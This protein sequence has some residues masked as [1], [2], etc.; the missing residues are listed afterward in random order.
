MESYLLRRTVLRSISLMTVFLLVISACI[1]VEFPDEDATSTRSDMPSGPI[2]TTDDL[3]HL[4]RSRN[5]DAIITGLN[6]IKSMSTQGHLLSALDALWRYDKQAY[7]SV[8]WDI[9]E[10]PPIRLDIADVLVQAHRNGY[11]TADLMGIHDYVQEQLASDNF[12]AVVKAAGVAR[13]F[14]D[15]NDVI[16]MHQLAKQKRYLR[17]M[18]VYLNGMCIPDADDAAEELLSSCRGSDCEN[19]RNDRRDYLDF[20]QEHDYCENFML[21]DVN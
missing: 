8:P 11:M 4:I 3:L 14:D 2:A 1:E 6:E 7:P 9:V 5:V 13:M 18:L 16:T 12:D 10:L 21:E 19:L 20:K 15:P 17:P